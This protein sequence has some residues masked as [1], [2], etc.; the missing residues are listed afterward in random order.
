MQH[1]FQQECYS[2]AT[3]YRWYRSFQNGH[4]KVGDMFHGCHKTKRT[5]KNIQKCT[6]SLGSDQTKG[7]FKLCRESQLTYGTVH[8]ILHRDLELTKC[9]PKAVPHILT[10]RHKQQRL[11]FAQ[12]LVQEYRR[13]WNCLK[14]LLTTDESW[15]YVQDPWLK[16]EARE[17][18]QHNENRGQ[19][20]KK[21]SIGQKVMLVPFFDT[22]GLV[23]LEYFCNMTISK[24]VFVP[25]L[26]CVRTS[27]W[28]RRPEAWENREE[29]LLYMDNVPAHNSTPTCDYL[30]SVSWNTMK[31][32]PYSPDLSPEDFFLFPK[33]KKS[34]RG[35]DFGSVEALTV[36]IECKLHA[37]PSHEWTL[38]F[39][40]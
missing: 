3:V 35:I 17:W 25:L 32:P 27:I 12:L 16:L 40:D 39:E 1:T 34:P 23:H 29:Y 28:I 11:Q 30:A 26:Q 4:T 10:D 7:I 14:C 6:S 37:I 15:F 31:H 38:C 24:K 18:L 20:I 8:H 5:D 21:K 33:L 13:D 36:A 19:V 2:Q 22:Q 9:A